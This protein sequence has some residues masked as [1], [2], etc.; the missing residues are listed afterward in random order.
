VT[1]RDSLKVNRQ[2]QKLNSRSTIRFSLKKAAK[3]KFNEAYR[4]FLLCT[5][6]DFFLDLALAIASVTRIDIRY[7][8]K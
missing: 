6:I 8:G 5:G 2:Q 3:Y 7:L 1:K 4:I